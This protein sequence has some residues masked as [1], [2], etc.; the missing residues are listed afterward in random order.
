MSENAKVTRRSGFLSVC[1]T[2][3]LVL[4]SAWTV[5]LGL[6]FVWSWTAGRNEV[7]GGGRLQAALGVVWLLGMVAVG[8]CFRRTR[9]AL[10]QLQATEAQ[11]RQASENTLEANQ[12]LED[13]NRQL[14]GAIGDANQ[15]AAAAEIANNAKSEFL[16]NMSHEIRTPMTAI[17][18]YTDLLSDPT[19]TASDRDNYVAVVRRNGEHLLALINDILDLAKIESGKLSVSVESCSVPSVIADMASLMR[20]RAD[21]R[22]NQLNIE[23]NGGLPETIQSDPARLR[24][25]LVNLVGNAIKFTEKGTISVVVTFLPT[26]RDGE[27]AVQFD[28][29]DTG[30]G[31]SPEKIEHLFQPFVQA[32]TSTSRKF[33][34]TGLGLP[35]TRH[36]AELLGGRPTADSTPG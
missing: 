7:I 10:L 20:V 13:I 30:I 1:G 4:W 29:I 6:V 12:E 34:G 21:Q 24:Q 25:A 17:L 18:G 36:I 35:I 28:V 16:A 31:I 32:D 15:M 5:A 11:A 23:Y 27:S 8:L 33:G 19:V 2:D 26:W 14:E 22:G 9:R 3:H